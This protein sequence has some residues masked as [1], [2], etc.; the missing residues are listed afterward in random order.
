M[1]ITNTMMINSTMRN[2]NSSKTNLSSAENQMGTEKKITR[3]SDDPIIA[4]RALSLRSSLSEISMYLTN[5][6][7]EAESWIGITESALDNMDSALGDIYELCTQGASDQFT[8]ENR[9]AI[10]QVLNQYKEAVYTEANANYAGRY[11]FT[12]YRTD[13]SFTFTDE[14][15]AASLKYRIPQKL[16]ASDMDQVS[17]M[18]KSVDV[19]NITDISAADMPEADKV[20][21]LR[22]AYSGC[23]KDNF[24]AISVDGTDYTPTAVTCNEYQELLENGKATD[25]FYYV[26]DTGELLVSDNMYETVKDAKDIEFTYEKEGFAKGDV[27]PEM[28]YECQDITDPADIKE[29]HQKDGGQYITYTINYSQDL[30]VNTLGNQT[31]SHDIARDV[32]DMCNALQQVSDIEDKIAKLK[33]MKESTVYSDAEKDKIQ[34]MI[35]ASNK[36][37]DYAKDSMK[38]LFSKEMPRVKAYQQ[39][40]DLQIADLGAR[41]ARLTLAKSRLTEQQTTFKDLKSQNEDADLEEIVVNYTSAKTLY[42][43]AL[44]AAASCVKQS[45]LDY[46]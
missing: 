41:D 14:T 16:N 3:P 21:R 23:S 22:L 9:S 35:D 44:N 30:Q 24:G 6:I 11:C 38:K 42:Q 17:I 15:E 5:N 27:R 4:I 37:L 31:L 7:P 40:V 45:L 13:T 19:T 32:D 46:I 33:S 12:G 43:A 2:V 10:I 8:I 39:S 34:T 1:R 36:E 29:Y 28:Y 20:Y 18:K 26:Y 25:D